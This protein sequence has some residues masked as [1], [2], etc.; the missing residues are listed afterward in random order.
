[1]FQCRK[2]HQI[3]LKIEITRGVTHLYSHNFHIYMIV[4]PD[5][6]ETRCNF[7]C[8]NQGYLWI[9]NISFHLCY[10]AGSVLTL[11]TSLQFCNTEWEWGRFYFIASSHIVISKHDWDEYT[12]YLF[13]VPLYLLR[14]LA[15]VLL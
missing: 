7:S 6:Y 15:A 9:F 12:E 11:G 4:N 3:Y 2:T 8:V 5:K 14:S 1:M 13:L 10:I